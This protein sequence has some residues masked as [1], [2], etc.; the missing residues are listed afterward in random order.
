MIVTQVWPQK[1]LSFVAKSDLKEVVNKI[2]A[3]S[4]NVRSGT[5]SETRWTSQ[6]SL[7]NPSLSL[8]WSLSDQMGEKSLRWSKILMLKGVFFFEIEKLPFVVVFFYS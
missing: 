8:M 5:Q 2:N 3:E 7:E 1:L 6:V 4:E